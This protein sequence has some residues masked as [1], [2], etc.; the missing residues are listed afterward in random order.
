MFETMLD[1]VIVSVE[2]PFVPSTALQVGGSRDQRVPWQRRQCATWWWWAHSNYRWMWIRWFR[3][4]ETWNNPKAY[5]GLLFGFEKMLII[6][7]RAVFSWCVPETENN[8]SSCGYVAVALAIP[9]EMLIHARNFN[10]ACH[11]TVLSILVVMS[12]TFFL[13]VK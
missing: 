11:V 10:G 4:P 7:S 3:H 13:Y 1:P 12:S 2:P 6:C 5:K 9:A 8:S